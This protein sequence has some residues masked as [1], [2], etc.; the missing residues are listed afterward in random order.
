MKKMIVLMIAL[1]TVSTAWAE[2]YSWEDKDGMHFTDNPA[3]VPKKHREK[4]F[5][6]VKKEYPSLEDTLT[7][8]ENNQKKIQVQELAVGVPFVYLK[9][10]YHNHKNTPNEYHKNCDT[11]AS[12]EKCQYVYTNNYNVKYIYTTNGIVTSY[13]K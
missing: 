8:I 13:S 11:Y 10:E 4:V 5:K 6:N 3:S 9:A 2:T 1:F 12:G 7:R